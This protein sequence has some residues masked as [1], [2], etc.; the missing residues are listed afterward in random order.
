M[1]ITAI[2]ATSR[3]VGILLHN[4]SV[5]SFAAIVLLSADADFRRV[6]EDPPSIC[7]AGMLDL[8]HY[9]ALLLTEGLTT[10]EEVMSVVSVEE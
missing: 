8:K 6:V 4:I 1:H 2:A 10:V 7:L 3:V 9:A 5:K